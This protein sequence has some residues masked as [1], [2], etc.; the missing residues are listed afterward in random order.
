VAC[1]GSTAARRARGRIK[2]AQSVGIEGIIVV[3]ISIIISAYLIQF[4][5]V[6]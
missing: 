5:L 4:H 3:I 1:L 2:K 6:T